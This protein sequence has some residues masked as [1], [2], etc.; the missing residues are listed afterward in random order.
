MSTVCYISLPKVPKA[1]AAL[2]YEADKKKA[3]IYH[4]VNSIQSREYEYYVYLASNASLDERNLAFTNSLDGATFKDCFK[5]QL[6]F[7]FSYG[8]LPKYEEQFEYILCFSSLSDADKAFALDK[9]NEK[10]DCWQRQMLYDALGLIL[11]DGEFAE[12]FVISTNHFDF[13]PPAL[14]CTINLKDVLNLDISIHPPK[15]S[16]EFDS[17]LGF[18]LTIAK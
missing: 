4:G 9:L 18:K 1:L 16:A 8:M 14:E 12:I 7:T 5:N 10:N 17:S 13:G 11:D 3:G 2:D 15:S 6:T